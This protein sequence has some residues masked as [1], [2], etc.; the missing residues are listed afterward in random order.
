M[1][2][3]PP[4]PAEPD[5]D[6]TTGQAVRRLLGP[7]AAP[8][9]ALSRPVPVAG[10]R[11][12]E[13]RLVEVV[14]EGGM[15]TTFRAVHLRLGR[16]VAVKVLRPALLHDSK[17]V[18]RFHREA[19]AIGRLQH[20]NIVTATDAGDADWVLYLAMELVA[21]ETLSQRVRRAGPLPAADACRTAAAAA[22]ALH[23]AHAAGIVHRDVKPS[24]LMVTPDGTVKLLDLG[25]ARLVAPDPS[26]DDA[27]GVD[28]TGQHSDGRGAIGTSDY[29]APEQWRCG[30]VDAR[31]D[32]YGLG[33][34]LYY[35]LT[36]KPPFAGDS[37]HTPYDK[38]QL[39]LTADPPAVAK[40]R[41]DVPP[42]VD[43]VLGKLLAKK[44]GDRFPDAAAAADALDGIAGAPVPPRRGRRRWL[45]AAAAAACVVAAALGVGIGAAVFSRPAGAGHPPGPPAAPPVAK[46]APH[47]GRLPLTAAEAVALQKAWADYLGRPVVDE[48]ADGP[49]MV[50]IPPTVVAEAKGATVL[51]TPFELS[52]TEV[53]VGQFRRFVQ[54][55]GYKTTAERIGNGLVLRPPPTGRVDVNGLTWMAPGFDGQ[56]DDHPVCLVSWDDAVAYCR[57]LSDRAGG[58]VRLPDE[59]EWVWA[60]RAGRPGP[61]P[62]P[63]DAD[64][65]PVE[66]FGWTRATSGGTPSPVRLLRPNAW[67]LYDVVG[68]VEEWSR[69]PRPNQKTAQ[70]ALPVLG[71]AFDSRGAGVTYAEVYF[72]PT[73][74]TLIGFR[75]LRVVPAPAA[76]E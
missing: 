31:A 19:R 45:V 30:K 71:G 62:R 35:L 70:K 1:S 46:V 16:T 18:A 34:T 20:P 6:P 7:L 64:E 21:G 65:A 67:G 40:A 52:E 22:R 32:Q 43:R 13:Y 53:T 41:A 69:Q 24:N 50:L 74:Y 42:G 56:T 29:M 55:T 25:L 73:R 36:A 17:A 72:A 2:D 76:R 63:A 51:T 49:R 27:P 48:L 39:H 15:G 14:G 5:H 60:A 28:D 10:D 44:P 33:C 12:G 54:D 57:W 59:W 61:V 47:P 38:M 9:P 37:R 3:P 26:G 8:A 23:H 11:V 75:V 58:E 4:T 66:G 68:N